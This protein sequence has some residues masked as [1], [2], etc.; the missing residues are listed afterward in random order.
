M[1]SPGDRVVFEGV[2]IG[3]GRREG[4]LVSI[5][6]RAVR[7]RW[8]DGTESLLIPGPGAMRVV[9]G[10][11]ASATTAKKP[12]PRRSAAGGKKAKRQVAVDR[13]V[14]RTVTRASSKKKTLA[15]PAKKGKGKKR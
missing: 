12:S 15:T 2:K 13:A 7:V 5:T 10:S 9:G 14:A 8:V 1:P 3:G 6:G 11:A 4:E